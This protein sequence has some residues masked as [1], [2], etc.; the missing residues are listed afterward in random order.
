M[1]HTNSSKQAE[2]YLKHILTRNNSQFG[3]SSFEQLCSE[4]CDP[5]VLTW[6]ILSLYDEPVRVQ[7]PDDKTGHFEM[8]PTPLDSPD[9][10]GEYTLEA[11][12]RIVSISRELQTELPRLMQVPFIR[13][14]VARHIL[15]VDDLLSGPSR[16]LRNKQAARLNGLTKLGY[17][18]RQFGP[19]KRPHYTA[20]LKEI[21]THI[22]ERTG[23]WHDPLVAKILN[24]L[25]PGD[26]VSAEGLKVWRHRN[27]VI[28]RP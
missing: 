5:I 19:Q 14:L 21:Y 8:R 1:A 20:R 26:A 3:W 10:R 25:R 13:E 12:D 11:L 18:A 2:P 22:H 28:D 16:F 9:A 27:G 24:D 17:F 4:G 23:Q 6:C 15:P 7:G